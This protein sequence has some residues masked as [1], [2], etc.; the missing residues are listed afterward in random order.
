MNDS[1]NTRHAGPFATAAAA[2]VTAATIIA[3]GSVAVSQAKAG[4]VQCGVQQQKPHV[5]TAPFTA[6]FI[7]QTG[8]K[9]VVGP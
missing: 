6:S 5:I 9:V 1:R 2:V 8:G 3:V 7:A 4:G